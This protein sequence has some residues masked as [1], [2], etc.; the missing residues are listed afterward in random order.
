MELVPI[1]PVDSYECVKENYVKI[2]CGCYLKGKK[3]RKFD[4]FFIS[5]HRVEENII[6]VSAND[7]SS[8]CWS[9]VSLIPLIFPLMDFELGIKRCEHKHN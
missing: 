2:L 4:N 7:P 3:R 8:Q 1:A 6:V 9:I 5:T